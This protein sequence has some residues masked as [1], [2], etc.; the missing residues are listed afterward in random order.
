MKNLYNE[1]IEVLNHYNLKLIDVDVIFNG[2]LLKDKL[3][4]KTKLD[5]DYNNSCGS[6]YFQNIQLVID[7]Y[8][9]F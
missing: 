2:K 1:T 3:E 6:L 7:D 4:I 9:W 5:Y 8:T